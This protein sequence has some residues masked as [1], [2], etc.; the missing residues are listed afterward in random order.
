M[1]PDHH[2]TLVGILRAPEERKHLIGRAFRTV[3]Q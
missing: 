3:T 2:H 1:Q